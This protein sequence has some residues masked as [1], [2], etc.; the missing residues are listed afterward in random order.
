MNRAQASG[1]RQAQIHRVAGG[2]VGKKQ[3][4][5]P[6]PASRAAPPPRRDTAVSS[7]R[8]ADATTAAAAGGGARGDA[9]LG[10]LTGVKVDKRGVLRSRT[11]PRG[12]AYR[13]DVVCDPSAPAWSLV[14]A[15]PPS[16]RQQVKTASPSL[17]ALLTSPGTQRRAGSTGGGDG[18]GGVHGGGGGGG[19]GGSTGG[20]PSPEEHS[21]PRRAVPG[22]G[23]LG[24]AAAVSAASRASRA[25]RGAASALT[26]SICAAS[27]VARAVET[28][29]DAHAQPRATALS[30]P[31]MHCVAEGETMWDIAADAYGDGSLFVVIAAANPELDQLMTGAGGLVAGSYL[32]LPPP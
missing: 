20:R 15:S 29:R 5:A 31:R 26:A 32:R 16:P 9:G 1:A 3:T 7:R 28:S 25:R 18:A 24:M 30:F 2:A 23:A 22:V 4:A 27:H 13:V 19:G 10:P 6:R 17:A 14:P 12:P 11:A 8:R 21:N